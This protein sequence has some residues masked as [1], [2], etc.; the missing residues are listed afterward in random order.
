M[1]SLTHILSEP[2][3]M[4]SPAAPDN[5]C[6]WCQRR[7]RQCKCRPGRFAPGLEMRQKPYFKSKT[8]KPT[9]LGW[10]F[11]EKLPDKKLR[12]DIPLTCKL[13]TAKSRAPKLQSSEESESEWQS[14][15]NQKKVKVTMMMTVKWKPEES[16]SGNEN[17][18]KVKVTMM[19]TA[20]WKP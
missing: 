15:E 9:I 17:L 2:N 7:D 14:N 19:L 18:E 11:K 10:F 6:Q 3:K 8:L 12:Y 16:E 1:E 20:K 4:S 5:G 13:Y